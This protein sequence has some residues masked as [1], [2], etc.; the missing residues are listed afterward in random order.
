M[1]NFLRV[2]LKLQCYSIPLM[3]YKLFSPSGVTIKRLVFSA[4]YPQDP[5]FAIEPDS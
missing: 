3:K 5:G 4:L 2:V 1:H